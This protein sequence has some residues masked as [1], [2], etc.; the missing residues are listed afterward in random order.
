MNLVPI[1]VHLVDNNNQE[2]QL[3]H[4]ENLIDV[5]R[6]MLM[7]KQKKIRKISKQNEFLDEIRDDYGKYY[8]YIIKQKKDQMDALDLL[9]KYI[10][11]LT[12]SGKLSKNNVEDAKYEQKKILS[13][14][15]S[16]KHN[17]DN[18]IKDTDDVD[19][20]LNGKNVI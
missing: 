2:Q 3:L 5:K 1:N 14:I 20:L 19:S 15:K 10:H 4:I 9:N 11:D 12:V 13:E 16:I 7:D 17:L 6:K 18:I 8:S